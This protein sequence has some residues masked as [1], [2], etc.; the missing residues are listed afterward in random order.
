MRCGPD[1]GARP[2]TDQVIGDTDREQGSCLP[3]S[4]WFLRSEAGE[5]LGQ[6]YGAVPRVGDRLEKPTGLAG[7]LIVSVAELRPTCSF[8]RFQVTVTAP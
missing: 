3:V 1:P 2:E 8:R 4:N 7:W 5:P 6:T